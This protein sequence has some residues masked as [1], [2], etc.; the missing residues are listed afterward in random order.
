MLRDVARNPPAIDFGN[1]KIEQEQIGFVGVQFLDGFLAGGGLGNLVAFLA[2]RAFENLAKR[3]SSSTIS[4]FFLLVTVAARML[5]SIS[6]G[7]SGAATV[8]GAPTPWR[9]LPRKIV[10]MSRVSGW[11]LSSWN[12]DQNSDED[13]SASSRMTNG[14]S[15]LASVTASAMAGAYPNGVIGDPRPAVRMRA[16]SVLSLTT[17]TSCLPAEWSSVLACAGG[18]DAIAQALDAFDFFEVPWEREP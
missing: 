13:A 17:S 18:G 10:G 15:F 9:L 4:T 7:S 5:R 6:R 3:S 14:C 8:R 2:Q 11:D 1:V 16:M 12:T